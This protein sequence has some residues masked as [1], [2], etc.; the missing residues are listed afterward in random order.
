MEACEMYIKLDWKI[1]FKRI[2]MVW[3]K[4]YEGLVCVVEVAGRVR[5]EQH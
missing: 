4:Y 5:V 3:F 2:L 1:K